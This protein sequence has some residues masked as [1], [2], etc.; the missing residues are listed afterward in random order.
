[1]QDR[2]PERTATAAQLADETARALAVQAARLVPCGVCWQQPG[3]P[4]TRYYPP[5]DHLAR[6]Q[7]TERRA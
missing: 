6:Y 4:C 1:M 5:G 3:K 7:R 2:I